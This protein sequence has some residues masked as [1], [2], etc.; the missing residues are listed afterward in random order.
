MAEVEL[1]YGGMGESTITHSDASPEGVVAAPIGSLHVDTLV[2]SLYVKQTGVEDTGWVA[3]GGG[4]PAPGSITLA[5]L[6][7]MTGPGRVLGR[8]SAGAGPVQE[9]VSIPVS[10]TT[11]GTLTAF[12]AGKSVP[13]TGNVT[14]DGSV[15]AAGDSLNVYNNSA[16]SITIIQGAGMTLR[17]VATATT[18]TRTL[19]QRG[20]A[21]VWF[22]SPTEAVVVGVT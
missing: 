11:S 7:N 19:A 9:L 12:D 21:S 13:A 2:P 22:L 8:S 6:A 16:S 18:G 4:A 20:I 1:I 3:G 15:F 10:T 5:M 17:L 14:I